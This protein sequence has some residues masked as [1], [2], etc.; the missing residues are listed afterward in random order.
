MGPMDDD[1]KT[2]RSYHAPQRTAQATATRRAVLDAARELFVSRGYGATTVGQIAERAGVAVDTLYAAVGRKPVLLRLLVETSISGTDEAVPAEQRDYVRA[3]REARTAAEKLR[4]YAAAMATMGP[5]T[6]PVFL[7]LR[8][9]AA[10]DETCAQLLGEITGRR[11]AN[12]R[13][14]AADLRATG[15]VRDDLTDDEIADVVWS[16]NAADYWALLVRDRGWT[17]ERFGDHLAQMWTRLFLEPR[18]WR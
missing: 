8:D 9:A 16:T 5:R 6:A 1:V 4:L 18:Y 12:M 17:P 7:A 13:L 10:R 3:V 11:A 14:F 2:R 15:E